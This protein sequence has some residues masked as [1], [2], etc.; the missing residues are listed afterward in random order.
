[1]V[2][3]QCTMAWSESSWVFHD[4][5]TV[6]LLKTAL[7]ARSGSQWENK[8]LMEFADSAHEIAQIPKLR[9]TNT[10]PMHLVRMLHAIHNAPTLRYSNFPLRET[11]RKAQRPT[12]TMNWSMFANGNSVQLSCL[13]RI[14]LQGRVVPI[15]RCTV[16]D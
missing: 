7:S 1:M 4:S 5:H 12:Y 15:C 16:V 3:Q 10:S 14:Q 6:I 2:K 11:S 8:V 13:L 9:G